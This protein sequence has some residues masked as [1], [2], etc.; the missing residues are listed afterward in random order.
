MSLRVEFVIRVYEP[1]TS[2]SKLTSLKTLLTADL[3]ALT[4]QA[5]K[6]SGYYVDM[7]YTGPLC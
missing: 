3:V 4:K 6:W 1:F 2:L 5:T 7:G